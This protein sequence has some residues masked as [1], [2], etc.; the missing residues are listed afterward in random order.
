MTGT[1]DDL[2]ITRDGRQRLTVTVDEDCGQLFDDLHDSK[3][4][5]EIKKYSRKRSLDANAY[6][7]VLIDKI[8]EKLHLSKEQVYREQI[9]NIGGVSDTVCLKSEA[10]DSLKKAWVAHGIGWQVETFPSK[11]K[12]CTNV[13]LYYGSSI[14]DTAQMS[15]LIDQLIQDAE[16]LGIPTISPEEEQKMLGRWSSGKEHS[17]AG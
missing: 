12:G 4:V 1:L 5:I 2:T 3:V 15:S 11:L 16:G 6:A 10:V 9:R 8:A 13:T 7:W 17:S 14:Y